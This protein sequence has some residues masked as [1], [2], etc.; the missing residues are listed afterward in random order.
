VAYS[1]LFH[2]PVRLRILDEAPPP[3]LAAGHV[4][5]A[6]LQVPSGKL[7]LHTVGDDWTEV[8]DIPVPPGRYRVR[9]TFQPRG[10]PIPGTDADAPGDHFDYLIDL[11]PAAAAAEPET[12]VQ[13][14]EVWAG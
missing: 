4:V 2:V 8:P 3:N 9:V 14:P 7:V 6:D 5:G 10:K 11:W 12:L 1:W 13:G